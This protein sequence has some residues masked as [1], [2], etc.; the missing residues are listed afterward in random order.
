M[1]GRP[2]VMQ[3]VPAPRRAHLVAGA[4]RSR[5]QTMADVVQPRVARG[6]CRAKGHAYFSMLLHVRM[7]ARLAALCI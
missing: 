7:T 3:R 4:C 2:T 6:P 5:A 1:P